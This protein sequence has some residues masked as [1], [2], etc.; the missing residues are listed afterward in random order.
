MSPHCCCNGQATTLEVR[1]YYTQAKA[2]T[3]TPD[4]NQCII[5][6]EKGELLFWSTDSGKLGTVL[7][8]RI[9]DRKDAPGV[10][11]QK[12]AMSADGKTIA[13]VN[14]N[15]TMCIYRLPLNS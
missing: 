15:G 2:A 12:L 7:R 13:A 4:G 8:N 9:F 6:S 5:A 1:F 10:V 11:I 3:F 14:S